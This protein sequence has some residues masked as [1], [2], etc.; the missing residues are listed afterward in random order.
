[1]SYHASLKGVA[2]SFMVYAVKP[3]SEVKNPGVV[4]SKKPYGALLRLALIEAV[5]K[6]GTPL[7]YIVSLNGINAHSSAH[8]NGTVRPRRIFPAANLF[9]ADG[10]VLTTLPFKG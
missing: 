5:L 9:L 4:V 7:R 10:A 8:T 1:M 6:A 2:S 3:S